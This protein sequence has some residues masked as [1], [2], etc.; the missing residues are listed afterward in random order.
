MILKKQNR[1]KRGKGISLKVQIFILCFFIT[2][3]PVI[4]LFFPSYNTAKIKSLEANTEKSKQVIKNIMGILTTY[5]N[6]VKEGKMSLDEAQ[7][8]AR[9]TILGPMKSDGVRD[10]SQSTVGATGDFFVYAINKNGDSLM[11]PYFEG[12][13]IKGTITADGQDL[14]VILTDEGKFNTIIEYLFKNEK[15][16]EIDRVYD[17]REYYEPWG[18]ILCSGTS[19][20]VI[21]IQPL[22]ALIKTY[23][24]VCIITILAVLF[25][26]YI[27]TLKLSKKINLLSTEMKRAKEGNLTTGDL[28][29]NEDYQNNKN[30]LYK[31]MGA[32]Y[33]MLEGQRSLITNV[34]ETANSLQDMSNLITQSTDGI[35]KSS[36]EISKTIQ[37]I[38]H[39]A[40]E[41]SKDIEES[42][43]MT[44]ILAE[45]IANIVDELRVT[46][47]HTE[48]M[49][50][51]SELGLN[52]IN[53]LKDI[54][55]D[56]EIASQNVGKGIQEISEK[57]KSIVMIID[58]I[59]SIADQTNLLAL[60]AA[61]EAARAGEVGRGFAVVAEEIRNLAE[62]SS[63][64][65]DEIKGIIE[66]IRLVV[67]NTE[68]T[69]EDAYEIVE[70]TN[71]G[72]QKTE[73]SFEDIM[74]SIDKVVENIQ[75]LSKTAQDTAQGK[76]AVLKSMENI[77]AISVQSAASTEEISATTEEQTASIQ[78][79]VS[80]IQVLNSSIEKLID[81]V[82]IFTV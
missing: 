3:V 2:V 25:V 55:K 4:V 47:E 80:L 78:E 50:Q 53:E 7:E 14:G 12:Y 63:K 27:F 40:S 67:D 74:E 24:I 8:M 35:G 5:D 26:S 9:T 18:W 57:S 82:K 71:G 62:N 70:S 65:T 59:N 10:M 60:N 66:E 69:M 21:Y 51:K 1:L 81:N 6:M 11:H 39:G 73:N 42:L 33:E 48:N 38:A 37:E 68:K 54:L 32:F 22:K 77:A 56:N 34:K 44:F 28:F 72:L 29:I 76:D 17:Y 16:G 49:K 79:V 23:T 20:N 30:E 75:L 15:T 31:I 19:A 36:D 58:T 52:T 41:Q 61:I 43:N 13:N 64:A 45:T 46:E